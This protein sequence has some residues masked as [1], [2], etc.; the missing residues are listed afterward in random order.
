MTAARQ[1]GRAGMGVLATALADAVWEQPGG[2]TCA[3]DDALAD[4][5][6]AW[7]RAEYGPETPADVQ[8]AAGQLL[9]QLI[10]TEPP[11]IHVVHVDAQSGERTCQVLVPRAAEPAS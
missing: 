6:A 10:P 7:A 5:L 8:L 1:I 3:A 11:E 9:R 4:A 2:L